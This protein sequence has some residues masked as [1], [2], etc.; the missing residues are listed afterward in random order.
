MRPIPLRRRA[1]L[2]GL[3]LIFSGICLR[4]QISSALV[5]R[6]DQFGVAGDT[7][8]AAIYYRRALWFDARDGGAVDRLAFDAIMTHRR[9]S[10]LHALPLVSN[11][12]HIAPN[13]QAV[14]MDR[15]MAEQSLGNYANA[16]RDFARLGEIG[17]DAR[18][19]TFAGFGALHTGNIRRARVW[20][21][22]AIQIDPH[23]VPAQ[24]ALR[25]TQ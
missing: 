19:Y 12:L 20:W 22:R 5:V 16:E 3:A 9:A 14:L 10:I 2:V 6:G 25:K 24:R 13:D 17:S 15:A 11:Y 21:N 18:A 4:S 1:V 8:R 7:A 23:F